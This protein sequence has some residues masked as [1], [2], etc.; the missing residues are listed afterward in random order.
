MRVAFRSDA[1]LQIGSGHVMRCLTLADALR[2]NGAEVRFVCRA[3]EGQLGA[4]IERRGYPVALLPAADA[5]D[6][7]QCSGPPHAA[8]LGAPQL[9]DAQE[10][11]TVLGA[12]PLDWLVVDHYGIGAEWESAMRPAARRLLVIDDLA[13]RAHECD[14]LLDQ[15]MWPDQDARYRPH[16]TARTTCLLGPEYALLDPMYG[17]LHGALR[18]RPARPRRL[19]AFFGGVD[20]FGLS[21]MTARAFAALARPDLELDLVLST[22]GPTT[23]L[24]T[25]ARGCPGIR[26]HRALPTL[27]PL[28]AAADFAFGAG[29][30]TTWERLALALPACVVTV[31]DNQR[32]GA[33]ELARRGL[34]H[35][36]GDA[37]DVTPEQLEAAMRRVMEEGTAA[38]V[39]AALEH[40][41]DGAGAERVAGLLM[42]Q[43]GEPA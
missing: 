33:Q 41:L 23:E 29:G 9:R 2:E 6:G 8:W 19:F 27:A 17:R 36:L 28:M 34:I 11:R 31:A 21:L 20:K 38:L 35:W 40:V 26:L 12:A 37:Q 15:N 30:V 42:T 14:I 32:T 1:S 10:T 18:A 39:P 16:V 25:L 3:H 7:A 24:E 4:L 43:Q 22:H 5:T 13:D